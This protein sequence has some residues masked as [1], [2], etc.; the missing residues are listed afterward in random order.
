MAWN[1]PFG[2][3]AH[4]PGR[5]PGRPF[6]A[7]PHVRRDDDGY[8]G[9][10]AG[11][12]AWSRPRFGAFDAGPPRG[13]GRGRGR[14]RSRGRRGGDRFPAAERRCGGTRA[15]SGISARSTWLPS[16]AT[17]M[18]SSRRATTPAPSTSPRTRTCRWR[19]AAPTS[20]RRRARS[21]RSTWGRR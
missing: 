4:R 2:E 20:R 7:P 9:P 19:P 21:R 11:D 5:P 13:R 14:S 1:E 8:F 3:S 18:S 10:G 12:P 16:S 6:Y 15:P 17:S